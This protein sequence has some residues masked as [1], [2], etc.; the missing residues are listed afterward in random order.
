MPSAL[1]VDDDQATRYALRLLLE[2]DGFEVAEADRGDAG[3][4]ECAAARP[5][6]VFLDLS[7]PGLGGLE[8]LEV[9]GRQ[10]DAPPVVVITGFG[11]PETAIRAV[12]LGAYEYLT[13]PLDAGRV[14]LLAKRASELHGLRREL[15][16]MRPGVASDEG[17]MVGAHPAMQEVYKAIGRVT[18]SAERTTVLIIGE[19]GTGKELV[20]RAVHRASRDRDQPLVVVNCAAMPETLIESE[21]FGHER[22]SFTGA[23]ERRVGKVELAGD[24]TLFVDE[25]SS[26]TP[27]LQQRFLRLLQSREYERVG[28]R[29]VLKARARFVAACNVDLQAEVRAGRFRE[30]LYFRLSV[31]PIHLPPLRERLSDL[32][33]LVEEALR[34]MNARLG[35]GV[36]GLTPGAM[37][38]LHAH[39]WPGNVRELENSIHHAMLRTTGD[40]ISEEGLPPYLRG[41]APE[42]DRAQR[43]PYEEA[44]REAL[45]RF[46]RVYFA[47]LLEEC[48]GNVTEAARRSGLRRTSVQRLLRRH[49]LSGSAF[50]SSGEEPHEPPEDDGD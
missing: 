32:P 40:I 37:A 27:A 16:D 34:R 4:D 43:A 28:G 1:I 3:I 25:V 7:M 12:Q 13:K 24:G 46:E 5:D 20:A 30:D 18:A 31:F 41:E 35:R 42:P 23:T 11:T 6:V 10:D 19:T 17:R 47:G 44:R 33:L 50:R 45:D 36:T 49:G 15:E 39:R 9:L 38:S 21:L 8:V 2:R 22:G 26:L 48:G 14:R 29:E